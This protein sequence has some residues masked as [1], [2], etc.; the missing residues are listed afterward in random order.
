MHIEHIHQAFE[1][2][3]QHTFSI[4]TT[5]CA[6]G[7]QELECLGHLVTLQRVKVDQKKLMLC[8]SGLNY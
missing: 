7:L 2:L 8:L 6:F 5:K 1:I 4:K 3:R